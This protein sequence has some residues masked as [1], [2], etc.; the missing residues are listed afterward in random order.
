[1]KTVL[2][3][4]DAFVD[5]A[6]TALTLVIRLKKRENVKSITGVSEHLPQRICA[7]SHSLF[8]SLRQ[9]DDNSS[10]SP[11]SRTAH[12]L[13]QTNRTLLS[14]KT[15]DE[16]HLTDVKTLLTNTRGHESV[17]ASV[18]EATHNLNT[19]TVSSDKLLLLYLKHFTQI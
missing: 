3:S 17:E 14:I 9:D 19:S 16:I 4:H 6:P 5:T 7:A 15:H 11:A 18:T 12:A 2:V 10:L 8:S 1:M 13:H